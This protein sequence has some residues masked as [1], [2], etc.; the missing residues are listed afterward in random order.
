MYG[1]SWKTPFLSRLSLDHIDLR[2]CRTHFAPKGRLLYRHM[3][4]PIRTFEMK[5]KRREVLRNVIKRQPVQ[6][7]DSHHFLI[8]TPLARFLSV[9]DIMQLEALTVQPETC[10]VQLIIDIKNATVYRGDNRVF[11]GLKLKIDDGRHTAILGPNGSGKSTL[12]RLLSREL[13]AVVKENSYV[14]IWGEERWDLEELRPRMGIVS[15]D[16]QVR[17]KP[18]VTGWDVVMSG[19]DASIGLWPHQSFDEAQERR[20]AVVIEELGIES[21]KDRQLASM[22]TGEQRRFLLARALVH[23][24]EVLVLDEPTSGLDIKACF[25][26]IDTIRGLMERGKTIILVT[27]HIHEIPPEIERVVLLDRGRVVADGPKSEVLEAPV[28]SKLFGIPLKVVRASGFYRVVP[29]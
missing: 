4:I 11:D 17:Y 6:K 18:W 16:L 9:R 24:P 23:D 13:F 28:L 27:H 10:N 1:V 14:R 15:H 7:G 19:F 8:N 21:L 3:S 26:Y 25:Q 2:N 5:K 12:L 22:S 20:A 29:G